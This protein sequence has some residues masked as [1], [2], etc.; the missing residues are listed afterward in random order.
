MLNTKRRRPIADP[1][2]FEIEPI[3]DDPEYQA[4]LAELTRLEE[5]VRQ[6]EHT[7]DGKCWS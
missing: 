1:A 7:R 2:E 3:T 4:A 5:R 6:A